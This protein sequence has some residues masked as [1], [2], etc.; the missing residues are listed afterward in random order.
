MKRLTSVGREVLVAS[1]RIMGPEGNFVPVG[2]T[3]EI[4]V[5]SEQVMAE[6]WKNPEATAETIKDGWLHTGDMGYMDEDG[7]IFLV[8]RKND[9]IISGGFNVYP[10]EVEDVLYKHQAILEAAVIGVPDE[11]WGETVKAVVTLKEGMAVTQEEIIDHCRKYLASYKKPTSVDFVDELPK[12]VNG[13]ILKKE[14][15][16]P[17]WTNKDRGIN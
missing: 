16:R 2:E 12:N 6:Y 13:K 17:Y 14:L 15:K 9:M 5:K 3:A 1:V 8:D 4:V 11:K 10:R 7:Y